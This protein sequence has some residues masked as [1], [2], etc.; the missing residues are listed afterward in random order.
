[1]NGNH[2]KIDQRIVEMSFENQKFEKGISQSRDSLKKFTEALKHSDIEPGFKGLDKTIGSISHSFSIF[3]EI[4]VGGLRRIGESAIN[5]G[6]QI[7][8]ALSIDRVRD[9]FGEYELKMNTIRAIMNSTGDTADVVREKITK[10]DDYADKTIY[11]TKDMFDN[12]ATFTNNGIDLDTATKAMIGIAN[13]TAYAG[14]DATSAMYAYRNFSDAI[15]N[16]YMNMMDWRSISRVAKIGT[17][18]FRKEILKTAVELGTLSQA[19]IDSGKVTTNFE[20]T[21][22][23]QWL[24]ADVLTTVLGKYGDATTEIGK[25]AWE[26]AQEVRTFSGMMESLKASVGTQFANMAELI[27]GDLEEAK[28]NFTYLNKILTAAFAD[29]LKDANAMLSGVKELGGISNIFEGLKNSAIGFFTVLRPIAVAFD[30]IFPPK[31]KEQ[32]VAI[33]KV[34]KDF[35]ASL[36]IADSTGDKIRRTFAGLF[37]VLDIGRQIVKFLGRSVFELVNAFLPL[38]D[39]I[40]GASASLGDL[41][42]NINKA[43]KSSQIF[44]YGIIAI[45]VGAAMLREQ[46]YKT[47]AVVK[48]FIIGLWNAEDPFEYIKNAGKNLFSGFLDGIK[49]VTTWISEKFTKAVRGTFKL[50]GKD[51]DEN[52]VGVWPTILNVL[53]EVVKFISGE[54]TEGFTKFGEAIKGLDFNKIATFVVGGVALMFIQQLSDLTKSMAG[55]TNSLSKAV[56]AFT[57]SFLTIPQA[58]IIKEI[59]LAIGV[60]AASIW[61]LSTIPAD[62]LER[63]FLG[64][65]GAIGVFVVAYG[66]IQAINVT[67]RN[68]TKNKELMTSAFGLTG[69]AAALLIMAAAVKTISKVSPEDVWNST[70]VVGAM[71]G[72][73]TAYQAVAALVSKIPG[74]QKVTANVLGM[75]L[76]V[77]MLIGSMLLETSKAH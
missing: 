74:Q 42:V 34:F 4:A 38:G 28:K 24:T 16:G 5:T 1:M 67:S 59:A 15:S 77:S 63:A 13:A 60:L 66:L 8:K 46:L 62:D 39:G 52:V 48:D 55:F 33:T 11:S 20:D 61:V 9:G 73:L 6:A 36:K 49:M 14:Q 50:F 30:E 65:A 7:V 54:A 51:F 37:A 53:K 12:L 31:T 27:F 64:M 72:F 18:E 70:L 25:K 10:L 58:G 3:E 45:K 71:L 43:I 68:L 76:G 23:D 56:K 22:K 47:I 75:S 2:D 35:T 26:A 40:L 32:W 44:Q 57:K 19:Q 41:L 69:V 17:Q 21:L 29:P